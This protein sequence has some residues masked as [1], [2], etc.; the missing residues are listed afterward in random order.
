MTGMARLGG[1]SWVQSC[2]AC[3]LQETA[4]LG[5]MMSSVGAWGGWGWVLWLLHNLQAATAAVFT[6]LHQCPQAG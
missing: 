2:T 1:R 6:C 4:A 5:M 3:R